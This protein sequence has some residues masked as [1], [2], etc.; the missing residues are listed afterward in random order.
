MNQAENLLATLKD[1]VVE[2]VESIDV[3]EN[4]ASIINWMDGNATEDI[5]TWM[6]THADT[7]IEKWMAD[8]AGPL[9]TDWLE[10]GA[11]A[12]I[13]AYMAA[14]S[15]DDINDW[16]AINAPKPIEDWLANCDFTDA[17]ADLLDKR[18]MTRVLEQFAKDR[19]YIGFD[20]LLID[21]SEKA[22][23][24]TVEKLVDK[25]LSDL[26]CKTVADGPVQPNKG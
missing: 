17:L 20:H 16:M 24:R 21:Y 18:D 19:G 8:Y 13:E 5:N 15:E 6:D 10:T 22:M 14:N 11:D 12:S 1:I 7:P 9:V 3:I 2:V 4:T 23:A 26:F 25:R